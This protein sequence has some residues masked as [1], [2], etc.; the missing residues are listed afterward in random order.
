MADTKPKAG[1]IPPK[2]KEAEVEKPQR[3]RFID[4]AREAGVTDDDLEKAVRKIAPAKFK[5]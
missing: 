3:Q 5:K 4:A 1:R 2:P